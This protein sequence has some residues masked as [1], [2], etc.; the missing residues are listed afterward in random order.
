MAF[1]HNTFPPDPPPLCIV[2]PKIAYCKGFWELTWANMGQT[3]LTIA[4]NHL[5]EKWP[6]NNFRKNHFRPLLDPQ[7]TPIT[8]P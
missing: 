4:L 2:G 5:F 1:K 6:T 8:L 7:V 3:W